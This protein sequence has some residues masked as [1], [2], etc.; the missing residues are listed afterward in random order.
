VND[1]HW[2]PGAPSP[3]ASTPRNAAIGLVTEGTLSMTK[4]DDLVAG[5]TRADESPDTVVAHCRT[6]QVIARQPA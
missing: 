2:R 3:P 4:L 1:D 5:M 6:H